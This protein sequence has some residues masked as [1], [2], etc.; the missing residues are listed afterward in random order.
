M[1]AAALTATA[2]RKCF[3]RPLSPEFK[4]ETRSVLLGLACFYG[5]PGRAD[6]SVASLLS[7]GW[8]GKGPPSVTA[9]AE[10]S[11][12]EGPSGPQGLVHCRAVCTE[13]P[14]PCPPTCC[15]DLLASVGPRNN[16]LLGGGPG[17][18]LAHTQTHV[19]PRQC[20]QAVHGPSQALARTWALVCA[21]GG[22]LHAG[23]LSVSSGC[24]CKRGRR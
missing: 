2:A 15:P 13:L 12:P 11:D 16:V 14:V 22:Q 19:Q 10:N 20:P 17:M 24:L 8:A 5:P 9:G 4:P 7:R 21:E 6:L 23:P 18:S 1:P 3:R